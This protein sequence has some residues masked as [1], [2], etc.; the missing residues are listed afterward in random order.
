MP[1]RLRR[2]RD[3]D[4]GASP[5]EPE[6]WTLSRH[7]GD[8]GHSA[9][10]S[11][12]SARCPITTLA[13]SACGI[14]A[15]DV[16][17]AALFS[18]RDRREQARCVSVRELRRPTPEEIAAQ[19]GWSRARIRVG[20][21]M[22]EKERAAQ[23]GRPLRLM[24]RLFPP[25]PPRQPRRAPPGRAWPRQPCPA[26]PDPA[27]PYRATPALPCRAEPTALPS[28]TRPRQPRLALPSRARPN[29]C[30]ARPQAHSRAFIHRAGDQVV[31]VR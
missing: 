9:G 18:G 15:R 27:A 2:R 23:P 8:P 19:E 5:E 14:R 25:A 16:P 6:I 24:P 28:P 31:S 22:T 26:M 17:D 3:C 7:S 12:T 4:A 11:P 10:W 1:K 13:R 20:R 30:R 29:P 21:R